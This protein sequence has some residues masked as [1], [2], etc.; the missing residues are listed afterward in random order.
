M[1]E[2]ETQIEDFTPNITTLLEKSETKR[3]IQADL[4]S[5]KNQEKMNQ[6][7]KALNQMIKISIQKKRWIK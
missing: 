5:R 1:V 4:Q 6:L 3:Q 2:I 7:Q